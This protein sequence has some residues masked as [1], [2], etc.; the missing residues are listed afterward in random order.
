MAWAKNGTPD[1]LTGTSALLTITDM[2]AKKFS[3]YLCHAV[4]KS[5]NLSVD[6]SFDNDSSTSYAGRLSLSGAADA[7]TTTATHFNSDADVGNDDDIFTVWYWCNIAGE[8]K[9]GIGFMVNRNTAGAANAPPRG[10]IVAKFDTTASAM[11]EIDYDTDT[12][13]VST[14]S[15]LSA[16]GTD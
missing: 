7:T 4:T 13:T 15:N 6:G 3:V 16:L 12:G 1:T 14:D 9:L 11:T 10:E 5:T 2:T 8:E